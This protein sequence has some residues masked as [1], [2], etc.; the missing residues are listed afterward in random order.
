MDNVHAI[1][2][3]LTPKEIADRWRISAKTVRLLCRSL[4]LRHLK[5][6][7]DYR[8]PVNAVIEYEQK[9]M[10]TRNEEPKQIYQSRRR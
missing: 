4:K 2:E 5:F 7:V 6:G 10:I 9:F 3:C 8:I 1:S